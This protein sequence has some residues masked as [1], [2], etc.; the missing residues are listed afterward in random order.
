MNALRRGTGTNLS[1]DR[2]LGGTLD[3]GSAP[4]SHTPINLNPSPEHAIPSAPS[5][6]H[7]WLPGKV[8]Q[9]RTLL[10]PTAVS[11]HLLSCDRDMKQEG[12]YRWDRAVKQ[13]GSC[14]WDRAVKLEVFCMWAKGCRD[15]PSPQAW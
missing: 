4:W 12:S 11:D 7:S 3:R 10:K 9:R 5:A 1:L 2:G 13:E 8:A 14:R 15:S 6:H